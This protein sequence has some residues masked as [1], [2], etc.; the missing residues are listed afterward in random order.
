MTNS[1]ALINAQQLA[2]TKAFN[3]APTRSLFSAAK[4][5][6]APSAPAYGPQQARVTGDFNSFVKP[7]SV[8]GL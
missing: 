7:F 3:A 4:S 1:R 5:P 6:V 8:S 2:V